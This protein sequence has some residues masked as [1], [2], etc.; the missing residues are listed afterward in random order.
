MRRRTRT[1]RTAAIAIAV[2]LV[3]AA[4]GSGEEASAP[5]APSTP[6]AAP[7]APAPAAPARTTLEVN[8]FEEPPNLITIEGS[9]QGRKAIMQLLMLPL[10]ETDETGAIV[11]RVLESWDFASDAQSITLRLNDGIE[12]SDGTP[13]TATDV[14][15][16][17]TQLL[18]RNISAWGVRFGGVAGQDEFVDGTAD[19]ISGLV[20]VDDRTVRID[21][22]KPDVAWVANFAANGQNTPVLPAHILGD[23]PHGELK[24]HPYFAA[25]GGFS[26]VSGPFELVEWRVN[27]YVEF[28]RNENYSLG[29][30]HFERVFM[31][32][33]TTDV[34]AAQFQAGEIQFLFRIGPD[35]AGRIGELPGV[36][37]ARLPG[38]APELWSIMHDVGIDKRIRQAML[39]ALDREAI[40]EQALQGYCSVPTTNIRLVGE[41]VS[42]AVPTTGVT[43]Y[44]YDPD[45]ARALIAEAVADGAWDPSTV[46]IFNDR[47]GLSYKDTAIQIAQGQ[48]AAVGI[49]WEIVNVDVATLISNI[50][51]EPAGTIDGFWVSGADFSVDPS[52]AQTYYECATARAGANLISYCHPEL[53]ALWA[54][55]RTQTVRAERQAT[56][57]DAFRFMNDE[58]AS[59]YLYVLDTVYAS[60]ARLKGIK[61]HQ[62]VTGLYWDIADWYWEE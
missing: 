30:P 21:L 48:M 4:C 35:D 34:A 51:E 22:A 58:I 29:T 12:W 18:D 31:K 47:P 13:L 33:L 25:S 46:L 8:F 15:M 52:A 9:T 5:A 41:A 14:V 7:S 38:V 55:G 36:E 44:T 3:I 2:G 32:L 61:G 28:V 23:V 45:K 26:V 43:E 11:S 54:T 56:Y 49:N 1:T 16:T 24:D 53:D 6:G 42:W 10:L 62:N 19:T 59:I 60:D 17:L 57:H 40:C 20:L 39:F 37:L 27:E 50:R